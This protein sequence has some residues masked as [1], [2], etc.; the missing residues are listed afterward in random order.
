MNM[1]TK[2]HRTST[3]TP[4]DRTLAQRSDTSPVGRERREQWA[5]TEAELRAALAGVRSEIDLESVS[6][7]EEYLDHNELG[8]AMDALVDA[9]L[10]SE[11][12]ALP[13]STAEHLR[14]ASVEMEGHRPDAW[15]RFLSRFGGH[16]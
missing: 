5:R 12:S 3:F 10:A 8:L 11:T 14:N 13:E 4:S 6:Q 15:D 16:S 2:T 1:Y 9:A 7:V